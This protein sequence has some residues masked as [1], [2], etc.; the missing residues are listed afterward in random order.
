MDYVHAVMSDTFPAL[1]HYRLG[2]VNIPTLVLKYEDMLDD[3]LAQ[4]KK[5][6][7]FL[8]VPCSK[9]QIDCVVNSEL[10]LFRCRKVFHFDHYT[11][12][13][14]NWLGDRWIEEC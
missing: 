5:M 7:H 12:E 10:N 3:L 9:K 8:N 14:R 1:I 13:L 11:P 6:L 2:E 4:L